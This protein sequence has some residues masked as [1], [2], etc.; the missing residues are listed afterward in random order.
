MTSDELAIY[1][2]LPLA[3]AHYA[4]ATTQTL[5]RIGVPAHS[6]DAPGGEAA[7][8]GGSRAWLLAA[9][10]RAAR[11]VAHDDAPALCLWPLLGWPEL[12]LWRGARPRH[13][14]V[15][16]DPTPL[17]RQAGL[18]SAARQLTRLVVRGRPPLIV[19]HSAEARD[20]VQRLWPRADI[21][22]VRHPIV[23]D[24]VR[25]QDA[26]AEREPATAVVLGQYKPARDVDL[27]AALGPALRAAGWRTEIHGRGWPAVTGWDVHPS[28]LAEDDVDRLLRR[29]TV[30]VV[31]Y[32]HYYQSGVAVRAV[33]NGCPPVGVGTG[34]LTD[35]LGAGHPALLPD[36]AGVDDWVR[37][38]HTAAALTAS[39]TAADYRD[40]ADADWRT[41][42]TELLA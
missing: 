35:L 7:A 15:V 40:R 39:A 31:G 14:V 38:C 28:F 1:N 18:G 9:H 3:L 17:R 4:R 29:A 2:P 5:A 11:E 32:R 10:V 41:L 30:L 24:T 34:F 16:H 27:L 26:A 33:E 8:Q 23:T 13:A 21:R 22:Y 42:A 25:P 12:T 37:G 6:A 36:G 19:V 20:V